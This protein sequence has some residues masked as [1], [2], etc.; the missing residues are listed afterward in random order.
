MDF[1]LLAF[2]HLKI[3]VLISCDLRVILN[4]FSAV[5]YN[6]VVRFSI[7]HIYKKKR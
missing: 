6:F 2:T 1:F 5:K 3:I 4:N 7:G